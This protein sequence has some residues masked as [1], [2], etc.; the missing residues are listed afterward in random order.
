MRLRLTEQRLN[1]CNELRSN[2]N[3]EQFNFIL[4]HKGPFTVLCFNHNQ[5]APLRK[6][7]GIYGVG[8]GRNNIA[9]LTENHTP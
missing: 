6:E 7:Y 2:H 4:H 1:L 8:D 5:I 3:A 9:T